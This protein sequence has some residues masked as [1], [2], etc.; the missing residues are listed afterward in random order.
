MKRRFFA[1]A[2]LFILGSPLW[3]ED[4]LAFIGMKLSE[5]IERFGAPK[6]VFAARG[7]EIWQDDVVFRYDPGDFYIYG[8]RVWQVRVTSA[9][10]ISVG[11]PRQAAV[12]ALGSRAEDRGD[13]LFMPVTG[14]DWPL[15]LRANINS[16]GR[17][18]SIFVFRTDF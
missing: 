10:G 18:A 7:N 4:S 5:L 3:A 16:A 6:T 11:D 13:H 9:F 12:L 14:M 2:L 15:M 1:I 17:V 8:D